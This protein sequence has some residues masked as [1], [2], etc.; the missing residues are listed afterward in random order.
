MMQYFYNSTGK[1]FVLKALILI[2]S[3]LILTPNYNCT[4]T[5]EKQK[6]TQTNIV[7][8][9]SMSWSMRMADSEIYRRG[10]LIKYSKENPDAKWRYD[11]GLFLKALLDLWQKTNRE[12]YFNY[13][14]EMID[15]FIEPD[16]RIKTYKMSDYNID[17]INSGKVLLTLYKVTGNDKYKKAAYILREQLDKH[18]RTKE[19]GFWHKKRYPWQMWLDGIYMGL[20]FYA[21]FSLMFD[22]PTGFDDVINQI[23]LIDVHTRDPKTGLRYH[24]W[25]ESNKQKWADAKTGCSPNFWGRSMGWYSM[26]LIDVL[27]YIPVDYQGRDQIIFI[28]KDVFSS[29]MKYQDKNSGL[30]YQVLDQGKRKGNYLEASASS[31]F[32]YSLAKAVRNQYIDSSYWTVAEKGYKGLIENLIEVDSNGLINLTHICSVAGLGGDPYR[33]GS[34]EYYL[35]E[36]IVKNDLK[37]VGPFIMASLMIE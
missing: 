29:I 20:P 33:D 24:G 1:E 32:V 19:G 18:P 22:Q 14:L 16:G 21:E 36:P 30:W 9:D 11:L 15:S 27:D 37:G 23:L 7:I 10:D 5:N 3:I 26:A 25:D 13:T 2:F 12:K 31:M 17:K 8:S 28:M 6:N 34:Y 35:S 4:N